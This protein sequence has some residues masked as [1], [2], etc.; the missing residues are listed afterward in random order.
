MNIY[1]TVLTPEQRRTNMNNRNHIWKK[2]CGNSKGIPGYVLHHTDQTMF[3]RDP[4]RYIQWNPE[5]LQMMSKA[6]HIKLHRT[7]KRHTEES[8]AQMSTAH[9]GR[10]FTEEHKR[11]LS[12][13]HKRYWQEKKRKELI[14]GARA[15]LAESI[16]R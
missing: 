12:E 7:G 3:Y 14:N 13:S 15:K 11:R 9:I 16:K 10:Q 5:D 6:D 2:L 1:K 8:K 4:N